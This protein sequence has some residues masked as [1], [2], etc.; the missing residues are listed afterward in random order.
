[1]SPSSPKHHMYGSSHGNPSVWDLPVLSG[2]HGAPPPHHPTPGPRTAGGQQLG[3]RDSGSSGQR[4]G[5]ARPSWEAAAAAAA[6]SVATTSRASRG[7]G[8]GGRSKEKDK[9]KEEVGG[10]GLGC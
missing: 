8:R 2:S 9:D 4:G 7:V 1:M 6:A 10:S 3:E 5:G